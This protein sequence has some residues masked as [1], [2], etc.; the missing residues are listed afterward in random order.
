MSVIARLR[1]LNREWLLLGGSTAVLVV[2]ALIAIALAATGSDDEGSPESVDASATATTE[3]TSEASATPEGMVLGATMHIGDTGGTGVSLRSDCTEA[4][5]TPGALAEGTEVTVLQIGA[6][7][8]E[9]WFVVRAGQT[10]TWVSEI[11][12]VEGEGTAASTVASSGTG[13]TAGTG[14]AAS[15][16][17]GT[18]TTTTVPAAST[19]KPAATKAPTP[20]LPTFQFTAI[21]G[22]VMTINDLE[23]AKLYGG[24]DTGYTYLGLVSRSRT[25][26]ESICNPTGTYGIITS[27]KNMRN[28][29]TAFGHGPGGSPYHPY[30]ESPY[31]AYQPGAASPPRITV[32][33]SAVAFISV[34]SGGYKIHPDTFFAY[35]GC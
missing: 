11:Y 33:G 17:G 21:D 2:V 23:G 4:A 28:P 19:P 24:G 12:L 30:F 6:D 25:A 13:S 26:A 8:C 16:S 5:R 7:D 15:S 3:G 34:S 10:A 20:A 29:E 9:G 18:T 1:K 35:L 31:S 22:T 32:N 27:D 14:S